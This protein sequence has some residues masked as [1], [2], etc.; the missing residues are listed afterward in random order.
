MGG[1]GDEAALADLATPLALQI[2]SLE[3][4]PNPYKGD[5]RAKAG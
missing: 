1:H 4:P 2:Y 5:S 3:S